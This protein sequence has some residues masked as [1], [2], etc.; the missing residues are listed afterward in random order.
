MLK[1]LINPVNKNSSISQ[2]VLTGYIIILF[3]LVFV[4]GASLLGISRL[5][6]WVRSTEKVDQLLQQIYISRIQAENLTL[7]TD[8]TSS[9]I[10]DSL[11]LRIEVLLDEAR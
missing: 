11:T 9:Y 8:T 1:D 2:K 6:D 5:K 4:A 7:K 3:L 10:V